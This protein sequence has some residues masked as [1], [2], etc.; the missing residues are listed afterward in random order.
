MT[1][2]PVVVGPQATVAE[3]LARV[4]DPQ[5]SPAL[6]S[7]AF[8]CRPP[9]ETPTGRFLGVAHTQALLRTPPADLASTALDRELEPLAPDLDPQAV[10]EQLARYSLV[11]LPVCDEL[12]RLLG[13]VAVEDVLDHILPKGWRMA[14]DGHDAARHR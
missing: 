5:L 14:T 12:G 11:C 6:A 2:E 10:A 3:V 1:A 4:R 8:V 9:L 13:A 7:M